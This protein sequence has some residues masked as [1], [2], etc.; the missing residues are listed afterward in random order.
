MQQ[1]KLTLK[2]QIT[3]AADN[4]F[5]FIFIYFFFFILQRKQANI[6]SES[7]AKPSRRFTWNVKTDFLS[8]KM[9]EKKNFRM[10]SATSLALKVNL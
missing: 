1:P 2:V 6:L 5:Y 7:S 8:E 3:T 9:K 4:N 10:S